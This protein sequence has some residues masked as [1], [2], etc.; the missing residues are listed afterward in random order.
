MDNYDVISWWSRLPLNKQKQWLSVFIEKMNVNEE[1]SKKEQ[2][3]YESKEDQDDYFLG[4]N[5][6]DNILIETKL[7]D[8]EPLF[9]KKMIPTDK[10][11]VEKQR[12]NSLP[13]FK[14]SSY[15]LKE[16]SPPSDKMKM[17]LSKSME[18]FINDKL[19]ETRIFLKETEKSLEEVNKFNK[20]HGRSRDQTY[21][22]DV[23]RYDKG[24]INE[25]LCDF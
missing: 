5:N 4:N 21:N 19:K 9:E 20:R 1:K 7:N 3:Y 14:E 11:S 18:E 23:R 24:L 22:I 8:L 15:S 2:N 10:N 13:S 6:E 12:S 17:K 25:Y 16:L